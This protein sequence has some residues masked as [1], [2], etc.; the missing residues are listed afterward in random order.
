MV[1]LNILFDRILRL[2]IRWPRESFNENLNP[3]CQNRLLVTF[4]V[5]QSISIPNQHPPKCFPCPKSEQSKRF[6]KGAGKGSIFFSF[7][8]GSRPTVTFWGNFSGEG[9]FHGQTSITHPNGLARYPPSVAKPMA[10]GTRCRG[11]GFGFAAT[12]S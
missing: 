9:R 1:D 2:K 8:Q 3:N 12:V 10:L 6:Q 4:A 7:G 11:H 5:F